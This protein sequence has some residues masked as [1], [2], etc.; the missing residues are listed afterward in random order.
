M[1]YR[2]LLGYLASI[3]IFIFVSV[4]AFFSYFVQYTTHLEAAP[5]YPSSTV[6]PTYS[7][8]SKPREI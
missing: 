1:L 5:K 2:D 4:R 8:D 6:Q 3:P 7:G